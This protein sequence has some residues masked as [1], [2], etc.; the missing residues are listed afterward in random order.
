M[1]QKF[2]FSIF[3][4]T[5][6]AT[7]CNFGSGTLTKADS[8]SIA[9]IVDSS[10]KIHKKSLF[11]KTETST[12]F[13]KIPDPTTVQNMIACYNNYPLFHDPETHTDIQFIVLDSADWD[14]LLAVHKRRPIKSL[15]FEFGVKN[16]DAVNADTADPIYNLITMPQFQDTKKID[17]NYAYDFGCPC[18]GS[19][20][21]PN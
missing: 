3:L 15:Y 12:A 10:Y 18:P 14:T 7:A 19:T 21:C 1:K 16:Y 8:I 5:F 17:Y 4:I 20:C 11:E 9:R 6:L 13:Q 2:I